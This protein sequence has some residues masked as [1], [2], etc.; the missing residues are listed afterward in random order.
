ML[1]LL[2]V[3]GQHFENPVLECGELLEEFEVDSK[4][5]NY[6]HRSVQILL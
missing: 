1:L 2:L 6:I 3:W 5:I 4:E